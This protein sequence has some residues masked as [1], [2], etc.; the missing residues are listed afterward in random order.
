MPTT[1]SGFMIQSSFGQGNF[2]LIAPSPSGGFVHYWRDNGAPAI[3]GTD[4]SASPRSWAW[5]TPWR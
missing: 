5:W 4:P 2:E 3:P 1:A